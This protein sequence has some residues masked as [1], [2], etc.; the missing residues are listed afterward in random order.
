MALPH[1]VMTDEHS[2]ALMVNV[3]IALARPT[4]ASE[5]AEVVAAEIRQQRGHT[6]IDV[7]RKAV[8][9]PYVV[10]T[11]KPVFALLVAV[12]VTFAR[13]ARAVYRTEVAIARHTEFANIDI[14]RDIVPTH[15]A[16]LALVA[17]VTVAETDCAWSKDR[18]EIGPA[19]NT[20]ATYRHRN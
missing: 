10:L 8:V 13:R 2:L 16:G 17:S 6:N 5:G 18:T 15:Q 9:R 12:T 7:G 1:I 11:D 3:A 20:L 4:R 19:T 14:S